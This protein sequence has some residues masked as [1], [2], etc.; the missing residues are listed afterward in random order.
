M[1]L[2]IL[3]GTT[4]AGKAQKLIPKEKWPCIGCLRKSILEKTQVLDILVYLTL[5]YN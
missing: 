1:L 4:E 5:N 3:G 2:G